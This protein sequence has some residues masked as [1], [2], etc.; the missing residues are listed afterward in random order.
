MLHYIKKFS[1]NV[2]LAISVGK[3]QKEE[4]GSKDLGFFLHC[5]NV[6]LMSNPLHNAPALVLLKQHTGDKTLNSLLNNTVF[7][8]PKGEW[9]LDGNHVTWV[10]KVCGKKVLEGGVFFLLF[11]SVDQSIWSIWK[12]NKKKIKWLLSL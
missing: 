10:E 6:T 1:T 9:S 4:M 11:F 12:Q 3:L 2:D 5:L 8:S 7:R